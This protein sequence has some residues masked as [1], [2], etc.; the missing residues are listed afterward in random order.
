MDFGTVAKCREAR[1]R[2]VSDFPL[3]MKF[4][5]FRDTLNYKPGPAGK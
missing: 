3:S 2:L 1:G 5:V 4:T